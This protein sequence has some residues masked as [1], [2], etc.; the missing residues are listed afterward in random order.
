MHTE[1]SYQFPDALDGIE[2]GAVDVRKSSMSSW[3]CSFNQSDRA[4]A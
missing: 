4:V 3:L 1:A 2:M